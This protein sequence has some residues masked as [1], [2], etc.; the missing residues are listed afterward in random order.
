MYTFQ[1]S[2]RGLGVP[3][4]M[5]LSFGVIGCVFCDFGDGFVVQN[6]KGE[7]K[8]SS[9]FVS[10]RMKGEEEKEG[11]EDEGCFS[12]VIVD[13]KGEFASGM[14]VRMCNL[15]VK[16]ENEDENKPTTTTT[17]TQALKQMATYLDS[18]TF[19]ITHTSKS[20]LLLTPSSPPPSHLPPLLP[21]LLRGTLLESPPPQPIIFQ[22]L[23]KAVVVSNTYP[24]NRSSSNKVVLVAVQALW[25]FV[26]AWGRLPRYGDV[27]DMK[28]GFYIFFLYFYF[29]LFLFLFS[30]LFFS[31]LFF[32]FLFFS[33]LF[34]S[35]L[36]FSFISFI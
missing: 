27:E 31:F 26:E 36:L 9:V 11:E 32:S 2:C 20:H 34:F 25:G 15:E 1:N 19:T 21:Y 5:G 18:Q 17:K 13:Q 33:F 14:H 30:F 7:E 29:F 6:P 22:P 24:T 35:F 12:C 4:V 23:E 16:K 8:K 10:L 28:V 3:V